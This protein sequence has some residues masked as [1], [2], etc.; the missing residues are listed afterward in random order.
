M[1]AYREALAGQ[2]AVRVDIGASRTVPGT[3][4]ALVASY[5][6]SPAFLTLKPATRTTY[7][8][9]LERVRTEHGSKRVAR[10]ER[11]HVIAML[12][13]KVK[14]PA[15]ANHWLRLMKILMAFAVDI[16]MRS[17]DP[18]RG[19][20][21]IAAKS[22]GFH[23]W[24]EEE[25]A[26]FERKHAIGSRARLA[27][28]L[29]LF[30]A[31]RR[32]DVVLMGRQHIRAGAL[33][34]T[35]GKTGTVLAI[36]V[37]PDLQAII[38]ATPATKQNLTFLTTAGGKPFTAAGFGNWFRDMCN[39][40]GLPKVCSAHG[41]RKAACRRLAE[42]GC[43]EKQIAAISGHADLREIAR[44]TRAA[45]QARLARKAM[46]TMRETFPGSGETKTATPSD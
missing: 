18:T 38:E 19:I 1:D 11:G 29:L 25:I 28:G 43:S 35:Q 24:S 30:T 13:A 17:D 41:L 16:G 15:A 21:N 37:H 2:A 27:L 46:E 26:Q 33:N 40:A 42:A 10:L 12:A 22:E 5:L 44:Y 23:T 31:Q 34:I 14:T 32:G 36:P 39:E 6:G 8:N 20:K 45:D 9:I 4:G 7:R 3:V